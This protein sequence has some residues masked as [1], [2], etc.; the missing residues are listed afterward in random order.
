MS[1]F[2]TESKNIDKAAELGVPS[3]V[4]RAG[5]DRRWKMILD[6]AGDL[7]YGKVIE[8]GSGLG[9]Y[10]NHMAESSELAIGLEVD[11]ERAVESRRSL[12]HIVCGIGERLPFPSDHFNFFLS[13]EVLEHV[14]DDRLSVEEIFRTLQPGGRL[15][16]FVPNKGYPFEQ[17]G[18][19][20]R[21]KYHFGNIPFVNYLP[22]NIRNKLAP[23]VRV[24]TRKEV[25]NLFEGLPIRI[26]KQTIIFGAYDNIIAR[27]PRFGKFLRGLLQRLEKTPLR[28]FGLSHFLVI[29]KLSNSPCPDK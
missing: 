13:H 11:F 18:I 19:F 27:W 15:I 4:W 28:I 21:G 23:H 22:R 10:L 14:I 25:Q 29:E 8:G 26:I 16:L 17:H 12:D 9:A 5:Q 24:Y 2:N 3:L 1:K 20:W 6:A 7:L